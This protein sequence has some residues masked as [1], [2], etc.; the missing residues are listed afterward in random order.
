MFSVRRERGR[1]AELAPVIRILAG[2]AARD[3]PWRPGLA[4]LLAELGME[5]EARRELARLV[6]D[7]LDP[8]RESLWLASLAY[9]ADACGGARRRGRGGARVPR[10]RAV[11]G[12]NVMIGHLVSC[13]GA[14][15]RYL[16]MLAATLGEWER[17]EEHF[18]RAHGAEPA[19]G[20]RHLA[21]AHRVR[22]RAT[23]AAAAGRRSDAAP[24]RCSARPR[25]W[26][27]A[28]GCRRC[29]PGSG[30]RLARRRAA[31]AARTASP[32]ARSRSSGSWPRASATAQV[33]ATLSI[34]EHT[35]ANHVRS[36]LR[37]TGCANRTEA[38]SYAHRHGLA[39][40]WA[41]PRYDPRRCRLHDRA[42]LRRAARPDER[43][44][45]ADRRDQRRRGRPLAV[46]VPERRPSAHVLPVRGAVRRRR[47]W[48]PRGAPTSPPTWSS[49]SA[50]AAPELS[51][52][53]RDWADAVRR[54]EPGRRTDASK[55]A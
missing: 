27:S 55:P 34:S 44:R 26:R 54:A 32:R 30:A 42:H 41:R 49:R 31:G 47:S 7:G 13:Y 17:A 50:P 3:G 28:S 4:A 16:G 33:G 9:L 5:A 51:G 29:W 14:A 2:D 40:A 12:E 22:V 20:R 45:R 11:R 18:E 38:A 39:E 46:L 25:G 21:G 35:A 15:D 36:I 1:L 43:G 52:R 10:A 8:F 6:A 37:K 53:L 24:R 23:A 48:P 19:H